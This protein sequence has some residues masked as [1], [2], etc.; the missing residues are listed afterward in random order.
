MALEP[1][2]KCLLL[3]QRPLTHACALSLPPPISCSLW[4]NAIGAEGASALAAGL[5]ETMISN[6]K[7]AAALSVR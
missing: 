1:T 6:L 7:C 4:D 3:C 2:P 5:K